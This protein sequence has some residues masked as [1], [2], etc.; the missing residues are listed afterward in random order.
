MQ[1]NSVYGHVCLCIHHALDVDNGSVSGYIA[2]M[3]VLIAIL[4]ALVVIV[5]FGI[6]LCYFAIKRRRQADI[7]TDRLNGEQHVPNHA[8]VMSIILVHIFTLTLIVCVHA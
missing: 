4:V 6:G 7:M 1:S 5:A 3:S 8:S 2:G